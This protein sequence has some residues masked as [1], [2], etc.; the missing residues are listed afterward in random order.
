[1]GR[2]EDGEMVDM[3]SMPLRWGHLRVVM[4]ASFG[5]LTGGALA[6]L[7]GVVLPLMQVLENH[8]LSAPIQGLLA[9]MSLIGIM[10]GSIFIGE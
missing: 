5:Q 7:V 1:M 3:E 10:V 8:Q 6:T 9:S 2:S 4:V